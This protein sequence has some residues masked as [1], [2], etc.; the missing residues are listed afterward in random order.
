MIVTVV[1]RQISHI[2]TQP[3]TPLSLSLSLSSVRYN[4]HPSQHT[5]LAQVTAETSS[6]RFP[7]SKYWKH[8]KHLKNVE[9]SQPSLLQEE[10]LERLDKIRNLL[11]QESEEHY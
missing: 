2:S 10:K 5:G 1:R 7:L 8:R 9:S 11:Q 4:H 6:E 3:P